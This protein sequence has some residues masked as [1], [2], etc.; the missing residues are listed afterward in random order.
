MYEVTQFALQHHAQSVT[1][2]ALCSEP[3]GALISTVDTRTA[4]C[5]QTVSGNSSP[6]SHK[7]TA[8]AAPE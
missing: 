2:T 3:P 5:N 1:A 8:L 7:T 4:L 6:N